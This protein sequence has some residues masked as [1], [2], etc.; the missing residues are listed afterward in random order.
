MYGPWVDQAARAMQDLVGAAANARIYNAK[1][2]VATDDRVVTLFVDDLRLGLAH[3]LV[4][5]LADAGLK[6]QVGTDLAALP[7]VTETA[8]PAIMPLPTG[9]LK[10]GPDLYAASSESGTKATI[11]LTRS[12]MESNGV[13]VLNAVETGDPS[14]HAWAEA[15][16]IDHRGHDDGIRMVDYLD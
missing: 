10:A 13:Q 12:L 5:R 2:P 11:Q 6:A 14:G 15:G 8:K 4:R 7:P 1:G 9:S 3:R 16:Q